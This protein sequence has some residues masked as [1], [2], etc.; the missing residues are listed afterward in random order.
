MEK[1]INPCRCIVGNRYYQSYAEI[2]Y[3]DGNLS[4]S[5]VIG[6]MSNGGCA[7]FAGQCVDEIR[8]GRPTEK[9]NEEMLEKFCNIWDCWHLNN[10]RPY[11]Q[12]Q[13]ELGWIEQTKEKVKITK[14]N[15]TK[16]IW[17]KIKA[18]EK[19]ALECLKSG[20]TFVPTPEETIYAN[21]GYSVTT[22]NDEL[23]E[24]PEFYEVR[25]KDCLGHS[26]TECK[27]RGWIFYEETPLGFLGRPCPICGYKYGS[28]WRKEEV[29]EDVIE[30]LFN[31]PETERNPAW[32]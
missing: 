1:I 22:Y 7:S 20:E 8:V 9:W 14:W 3:K 30:W 12:H 16:E 15:M 13:K 18:A 27:T 19:R 23:P 32:V 31:L 10:M 4:I 5:G 17:D 26:N 25:E 29:P 11:C 21:I 6:P 2:K 28:S 24:H